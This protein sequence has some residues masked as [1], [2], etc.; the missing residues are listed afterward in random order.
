[1]NITGVFIG[2]VLPPKRNYYSAS[3]QRSYFHNIPGRTRNFS[4]TVVRGLQLRWAPLLQAAFFATITVAALPE[5]FP[6][7]AG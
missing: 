4:I 7:S 2:G 1:M 3:L 6:S 5:G